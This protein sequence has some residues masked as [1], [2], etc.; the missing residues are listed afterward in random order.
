MRDNY[1][2]QRTSFSRKVEAS[3]VQTIPLLL[4]VLIANSFNIYLKY[5]QAVRDTFIELLY[6]HIFSAI[7]TYVLKIIRTQFKIQ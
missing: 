6:Q 2:T 7:N 3:I 5:L 4:L 1:L